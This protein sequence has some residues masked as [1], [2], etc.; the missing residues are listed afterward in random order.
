MPSCS[1]VATGGLTCTAD[2]DKNCPPALRSMTLFVQVG[3]RAANFERLWKPGFRVS[4][5]THYRVITRNTYREPFVHY[6]ASHG[7]SQ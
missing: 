1:H 5:V 3:Y 2:M 4:N 6:A 7:I